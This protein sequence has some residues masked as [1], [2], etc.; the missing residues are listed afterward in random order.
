MEWKNVRKW[1]LLMLVAVD[2]FLAGNLVRQVHDNRQAERQAVWDAVAVAANRGV[3]LEGEAVLRLPVEPE[4]YSASRSESQEQA[5]ADALQV[6]VKFVG[7][8]EQVDDLM[9][10]VAKDFVDALIEEA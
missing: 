2:L 1:L 9:P 10:F 3:A 5:V 7:V 6:P 4:V 8:G